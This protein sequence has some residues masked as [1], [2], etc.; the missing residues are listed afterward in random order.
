MGTSNIHRITLTLYDDDFRQREVLN[1]LKDRPRSITDFIVNAVCHYVRCPNAGNDAL[2]RA[3]VK[4]IVQ[5]VISEMAQN[6]ELELTGSS[7][8]QKESE[9]DLSELGGV[10]SMFRGG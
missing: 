5:E 10:M 3:F 2:D 7:S 4:G 6:G 9:P 8:T 1:L